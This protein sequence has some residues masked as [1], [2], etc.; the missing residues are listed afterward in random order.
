LG[1]WILGAVAVAGA[2]LVLFLVG[3]RRRDERVSIID[4]DSL[5]RP[6]VERP[7]TG[8]RHLEPHPN[9]F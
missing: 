7:T 1:S 2:I 9:R 4:R 8:R 3:G 5:D 6:Q